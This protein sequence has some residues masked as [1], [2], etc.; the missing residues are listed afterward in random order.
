MGNA[1]A[2]APVKLVAGLLADS[3]VRLQQAR[4]SLEER[5]GTIDNASAPAPWTV[6]GYYRR[7]LGDRIWRQ[8]VGFTR[9]VEADALP[10]IKRATNTLEDSWRA[11]GD[12]KVNIDPG[13]LALSKLV[14]ASTKDAGHRIYLSAGIYAEVTLEF[15][16][17]SFAACPHTY[18][19]YAEA[20]A[21]DFFN[22]VRLAYRV[23][24][25]Q[26]RG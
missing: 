11:Q 26:R 23:Q 24:L 19:D 12:R 16:D 1:V 4:T 7:E 22:R 6:T 9:L 14:L 18:A 20:V 25:R 15:V 2:P 17:G 13:Y 21:L 10:D 3:E 5:F 8:F